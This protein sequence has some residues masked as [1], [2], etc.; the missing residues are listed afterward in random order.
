MRF[1]IGRKLWLGYAFVISMILLIFVIA[2]VFN[3]RNRETINDR[4]RSDGFVRQIT[5]LRTNLLDAENSQRGF[6]ITGDQI[7]LAPYGD[8]VERLRDDMATLNRLVATAAPGQAARMQT[9]NELMGAKLQQMAQLV[10][11]RRATGFDAARDGLRDEDSIPLAVRLRGAIDQLATGER[12]YR[13]ITDARFES[14]QAL[15]RSGIWVTLG[16]IFVL[17]A[18]GAFF[19]QRTLTRRLRRLAQAAERFGQGKLDERVAVGGND[20]I[21]D[22]ARSFNQMA[23]VKAVQR[24]ALE[25]RE[26]QL[27]T[28]FTNAADGILT[29]DGEGLIKDVN[30]SAA[31]AFGRDANLMRGEKASRFFAEEEER[32]FQI[33]REQLAD[34]GHR[35]RELT[36]K[37]PGGA[38]VPVEMTM[39]RTLHD[40]KPVVICILRDITERKRVDQLKNEFVS[41][42]SHELRTPLTSINGSLELVLGNV[43]GEVLPETRAML[44]IAQNN[45]RRLVRLINDILD[46]E[47]IES[48]HVAFDFRQLSVADVARSAIDANR[49]YG[50]RFTVGLELLGGDI[51]A[52]IYGDSDRL[53]QVLANLLSNAIKFSPTGGTVQLALSRIGDAV[54]F[55]VRDQGTGIPPEFQGRIFDKFAQ[56]DASDSRQKGGTGL[57]LSI[58]KSIVERHGGTIGFTTSPAGTVFS[59]TLPELP[60]A[61]AAPVAASVSANAGPRVLICEDDSDVANLLRMMLRQGGYEADIARTASQAKVMLNEHAY[62]AMTLDLILPDQDGISLIRELRAREA[63]SSLP[64]VVVS[65]E[66]TER[67]AELNGELNGDVVGIVDWIQKPIDQTRLIESIRRATFTPDRTPRILHVEDDLDI[68]RVTEVVLRDVAEMVSATS[69]AEAKSL[70]RRNRYDLILL[71]ITL[72]D[73]SGLELLPLLHGTSGGAGGDTTPVII[74]SADEMP[75]DISRA[76]SAALVKSHTSNE[77]LS[78]TIERMIERGGQIRT[79]HQAGTA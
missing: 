4:E 57:G 9:V 13:T 11:L 5:A 43:T 46:I 51:D 32:L 48:G 65:I 30:P 74:F 50:E 36:I 1:T 15:W 60:A 18:A 19:L 76:V 14:E 22:L 73:G 53:Q 59:F 38:T 29:V 3:Y 40:D 55:Q 12:L 66:A 23:E 71:D 42:V 26:T 24:R 2:L 27:R 67:A 78:R 35:P 21:S 39:Q 37:R 44:T 58:A 61:T 49:G 45:S 69:L 7:Y 33:V 64:I 6:L 62:A 63:G 72:G 41:T 8:A 68:L 10:T 56:A 20:E 16:S 75:R 31:I 70:L 34:P 28:I 25:A 52:N 77:Q 47:K 17:G 54:Q 79:V